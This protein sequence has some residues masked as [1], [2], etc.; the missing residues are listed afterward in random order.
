[1]NDSV[2]D[3]RR[4][5]GVLHAVSALGSVAGVVAVSL[6]LLP[7]L[8]HTGIL[9]LLVALLCS[10]ALLLARDW[11]TVCGV[12]V[13]L[14]TILVVPGSGLLNTVLDEDSAYYRIRVAEANGYR[15]LKTDQFVSQSTVRIED[16]QGTLVY[17]RALMETI[18]QFA[19]R[20]ER[21]LILG[22][23]AF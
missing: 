11:L 6:I 23:G 17:A 9:K 10:C 14:V 22:G 8:G 18:P 1:V 15:N 3:P 16:K 12:G 4:T 19:E 20:P 13:S 21:A 5:A 2:D 7:V